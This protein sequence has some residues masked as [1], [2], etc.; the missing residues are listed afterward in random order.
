MMKA[1]PALERIL[2]EAADSLRRGGN[3]PSPGID[4]LFNGGEEA[5]GK[6]YITYSQGK[7]YLV[8]ARAINQDSNAPAVDKL[9]AFVAQTQREVSGV[10]V[11]ITGEPVLE[12]DEMAQ[13]EK[14]TS[15]ATVVTF[16]LVLII[17]MYGYG[18]VTRRIKADFCLLVGLAYTMAF[19][20][21]TVGHLNILTVTF[22]PILIGLAIDFGVHLIARYEEE[23]SH[24]RPEQE[25][26]EKAMVFTGLGIVTGCLTTAGA[27]L[28]MCVT[29]FKGIQEMGIISG[30]GLLIC[31]LPMMV[32][33]PAMLLRNKPPS[34]D[35]P[36]PRPPDRRERI[37]RLWLGHPR[38]VLI[39]TLALCVAAVI[40]ARKVYFDYN[41]LNMQSEGLP[42][43]VFEKKLIHSA[44]KSVLFG[45]IVADS[46]EQAVA[47]E[48]RL[49]NLPAVASVDLGG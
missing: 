24:G 43:V 18:E 40:P 29:N 6:M 28:A 16:V 1:L 17:I 42:A 19:T 3:P 45:A 47:L 13:S 38:F 2:A 20:T 27:F 46:L 32:M 35:R 49:T 8:T 7:I 26:L 48:A 11:G 34:H 33:L 10:N 36:P 41:L 15:V 5:E 21:L 22:A 12:L 9:R 4:A 31:L 25:A 23:L 30:G 39:M 37:E 14:D 44:N